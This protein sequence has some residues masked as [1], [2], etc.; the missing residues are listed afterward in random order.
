MR[1]R[2]EIYNFYTSSGDNKIRFFVHLFFYDWNAVGVI[3]GTHLCLQLL[4]S[5]SIFNG[6]PKSCSLQSRV[7]SVFCVS[8]LAVPR[9]ARLTRVWDRSGRFWA[10]LEWSH[11]W[12]SITEGRKEGDNR[13][14]AWG[15]IIA[16]PWKQFRPSVKHGTGCQLSFTYRVAEGVKRRSL[17]AS[18]STACKL[19]DGRTFIALMEKKALLLTLSAVIQRDLQKNILLKQG[20]TNLWTNTK[21]WEFVT[22]NLQTSALL[23]AS[24]KCFTT[25]LKVTAHRCD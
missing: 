14:T 25:F 4:G 24:A 23:R 11:Q 8:K 20:S 16:S 3:S 18:E 6:L 13:R 9:L 10:A 22:S 7:D 12:P 21:D 5:V 1:I 15:V 19:S 2:M 17:H